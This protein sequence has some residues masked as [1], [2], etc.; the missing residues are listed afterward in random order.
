MSSILVVDD[1][2]MVRELYSA[3]LEEAGH[4]VHTAASAMEARDILQREP[5]DVLVSDI[6]MARQTGI[7]LLAWVREHNPDLPVILVTGV[8]ALE[9]A[10]EALRLQAYDYLV[11]PVS[12]SVLRRAVDRALEHHYLLREKH[13]LEADNLRYQQHLEEL[14]AE[15]TAALERRTQQ[16]LLLHKVAHEIGTLQEEDALYRNVVSMTQETFGYTIVSVYVVDWPGGQ[17]RLAAASPPDAEERLQGYTQAIQRGL[18]G[19][20]ARERR[21]IIANDVEEWPDFVPCPGLNAKAEAIFP[22]FANDN[23]VGLLH[24]SEDEPNAF[25][26]TDQIVLQTLAEYLSV[27]VTNARLYAQVQEALRAREEMLN[28]VSHELRTP[29][30]IIRGYAELM[31]EGMLGDVD[32][33]VMHIA[34]TILEQSKH[35]THLVDQLVAFRKVER[36]GILLEPLHIGDWLHYAVSTWQPVMKEAGLDLELDI[37]NDLGMIQGNVDY[38]TQVMNNLLDNA[39]KFSPKGSVVRVRAWRNRDQIYVAVSDEGIG[40]PQDQLGRIFERFYQVDG[41]TSRRFGGMGL[42]LALVHEIIR[43]HG[44]RVWAESE[45]PGKGLTVI[46]LLPALDPRPS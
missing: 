44:G 20:A 40:V 35:L 16:L 4:S 19:M 31:T 12:E 29:L 38:L 2:V 24:V 42:G 25:E 3:W 8:P 43:R 14:V 34:Q 30:T 36:E 23:L 26:E 9:T 32:D 13:R 28:N 5:I 27:A 17:I 1:E 45:G 10:V 37:E 22:I 39:R 33:E 18:L 7:D 15:R 6:R 21:A 11:K 41:G 46:F